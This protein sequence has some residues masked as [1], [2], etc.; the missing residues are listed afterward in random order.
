MNAPTSDVDLLAS[1]AIADPHAI[2][3][4]LREMGPIVWLTRHRAW[5]FTTHEAVR[6]GFHDQRLS[7]DRLTPLEARL[8]DASRAAMGQTFDLLR[9]W[10]VFHDEPEHARLREPL[11]RT[12]T[13][14]RVT[15]LRPR[16]EEIV[17]ELLD[18]LANI[19]EPDL[20]RDFAFPLPAIVIAELLGVPAEDRDDFKHWSDQLAAIVFGSANRTAGI[21]RA[22]AGSAKF[23]DYFTG[24]VD[25]YTREPTDNLISALIEVTNDD[26]D[27]GLAPTELVGALTLL[28]FGGHETT[29]NLIS[30][31]MHSLLQHP[32][33][34][35]MLGSQPEQLGGALEEL[36]R[37]DGS[38][39]LM[40]RVV[41]ENH[42][43]DGIAMEAGQTVFL[44]VLGANRDPVVFS[45]PGDLRLDRANAR[46]HL[47][48]G[49]G[50]H[51]CLGAALARLETEVA[52]GRLI[53]RFPELTL[54]DDAAVTWA[55]VLLGR[56]PTALP[57]SI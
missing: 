51:F 28:L 6:L 48:Y 46:S 49:Y 42:E 27:A 57:I 36:H 22:A 26:P 15:D 17:D 43:R 32:A 5:M 11:R 38:T 30:N 40:V 9:G 35:R 45:D 19:D 10:M 34:Q 55:E 1:D 14:S 33:Q 2:F 4:A 44:G 54:R 3:A 50:G 52:I 20:V 29:T 7:S 16:V 47:G 53:K 25:R 18:D 23:V 56:G 41:G 31:S 8:D 12:F 39:K 37:F 13:P 21:E 24:L